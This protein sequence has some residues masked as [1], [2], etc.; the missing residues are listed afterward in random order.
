MLRFTRLVLLLSLVLAHAGCSNTAAAAD[1]QEKHWYKG[2]LHTH[3]LW[4]DGNDFPE[5]I[6]SWYRDNGYHFLALSDH[7]I[8]SE[9]ERWLTLA[10]SKRQNLDVAVKKYRERFPDVIESR[11]TQGKGEE[12]RLQ[13]LERVRKLIEKPG[14]FIMIQSEE[15]SDKF[16]VT[17]DGKTRNL[18][19]HMNATNIAEVV[20][21]QGG[22][23]VRDVIR[24][25]FQAVEA[26]AKRLNR[27]IVTHLNH[28]NFQ[29]GVTAEDL[30]HVVE[31]KY[32]EIYNGH[33]GTNTR[34]DATH[35]SLEKLWDIVNTI[36][37]AQLNAEPPFGLGTDDSHHYHTPGMNRSTPGRG[38]IMLRA[39]DLSI[40]S[41][42]DGLK[43][44]DFYASSG[45][46]LKDVK[47]DLAT[48]TITIEI[49]PDGD[50]V[51]TTNFVG[52]PKNFSEGGQT[53]L[54]SDA[55][56]KTFAS[57]TG[58]TAMY[59][60]TGDELYVRAIVNSNKPPKVPSYENQNAQA[61]TQPVGWKR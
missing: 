4:S 49:E 40:D 59:K 1:A 27:P 46:M 25:N 55:V 16:P 35:A 43:R 52:T 5:M 21:A 31:E 32:F 47:F 45:V 57:A 36:R 38:W 11:D 50:A 2:N 48:R 33:P 34:G 53:P 30:A 26:Q 58:T 44:G 12:I 29:W 18:P 56:G 17:E 6:A 61:W 24:R 60:L 39:K 42:M 14:Q 37:L 10:E 13:P 9:G 20:Q 7:N 51:F 41:V 28:P 3:S 19:V 54:D 8:L 15:I 22:T 23:S